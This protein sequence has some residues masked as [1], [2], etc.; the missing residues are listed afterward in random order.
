MVIPAR[1]ISAGGAMAR[2]VQAIGV[3]VCMGSLAL[4]AAAKK[5]KLNPAAVALFEKAIAAS[6][7]EAKG[8][9]AF[10]LQ[11]T[12]R[13]FGAN[14]HD[15]A[16]VLVEF[17]APGGERREE[18]M[19]PGYELVNVSDGRRVSAKGTLNYVPYPIQALWASLAYPGRLRRW[20][21]STGDKQNAEPWIAWQRFVMGAGGSRPGN[22]QTNL[23]KPE[24]KAGEEC[25]RARIEHSHEEEFCFDAAS[26]DLVRE[27]DSTLGVTYEYSGYA[28]FGQRSFP[29]TVRVLDSGKK[30]LAEIQV[31]RIDPTAE[32]S[33]AQFLPP[34]GS[35]EE[36]SSSCVVKPPKLVKFVP[37]I[38]P[39]N[40]SGNDAEGTVVLYGNV[41]TDGVPRG[42]WQ[43]KSPS[44]VLTAAAV[45]AVS[46]WRYR[47]A[48][49]QDGGVA[50]PVP[51]ITYI[52]FVFNME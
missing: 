38:H 50:K 42:L 48:V 49:C 33:P 3:I 43:L 12:A 36:I 10:R 20:I 19:L 47:P 23:A 46:Q 5:K 1:G 4:P 45:E 30:E 24:K 27:T 29:R 25:V 17:W 37:P 16:G 14:N 31:E 32:P 15:S 51:T 18:T 21:S 39:F 28:T 22:G 11:A 40:S 44:R 6:D 41:G 8:A 26:G 13:I 2:F 35:Q 7:I 34:K 52:F 9:P